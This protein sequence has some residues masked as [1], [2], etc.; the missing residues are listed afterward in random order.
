[1]ANAYQ[2]LPGMPVTPMTDVM[3]ANNRGGALVTTIDSGL[4]AEAL[5][6][7]GEVYLKM[8]KYPEAREAFGAILRDYPKSPLVVQATNFLGY[9]Q[10]RGV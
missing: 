5:L 10:E 2:A 7:L 6:L 9:M 8:R 1:M 3:A 4:E